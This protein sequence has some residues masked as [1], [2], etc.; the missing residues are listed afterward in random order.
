M[1]WCNFLS[2]SE[3]KVGILSNIPTKSHY[4]E[5]ADYSAE[6]EVEEQVK[7]V[8]DALEK[9]GLDF[10]RFQ[11]GEDIEGLIKALKEHDSD[12]FI[13]LCEGVFGNSQLEM[14]VPS[15][16][17][18]LKIPYTGSPAL[19][20]GLCQN[21]GL[22]KSILRAEGISTP[23]SQ[24]IEK[25]G[26]W[27]GGIDYPLFVKPLREDA[28][29]GISRKSFVRDDVELKKQVEY[30]TERYKQPV[31][32]EK[33]IAGRELNVS[34]FG[35]AEPLI[36]PLSEIVFSNL[37][38]PR[39]VDYSAK[40]VKDSEDYT[41]TVPIC[42]ANLKTRIRTHVEWAALHA[43]TSLHCRD[44]ARIDI[45]LERETP[46]VI[47]V[48]PNP[49]ISPDAGFARAL[50][51]A[52]IDYEKFVQQIIHFALERNQLPSSK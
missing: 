47:E 14:A 31:L 12:V 50:K 7:A 24:V 8:E 33:Y 27:R 49:T 26:E 1:T 34:I 45:R 3:L 39:I 11:L 48:N 28:S 22:T 6:V 9:L 20:L 25:F 40:W 52:G 21:K 10:R 36:L 44:Y 13:N 30:V 4:G 43:Y 15:F 19:S 5:D 41:Q 32:V 42:P 18:L 51:A 23:A 2:V 29:L 37:D 17:E 46:Y 38:E 16:L 35:N